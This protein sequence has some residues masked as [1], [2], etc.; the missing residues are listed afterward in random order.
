M[1][2]QS[3]IKKKQ[4]KTYIYNLLNHEMQASQWIQANQ[5]ELTKINCQYAFKIYP[6][7]NARYVMNHSGVA[8]LSSL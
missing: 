8:K 1:Q 3:I 7:S 6:Y 4:T 5:I 2:A